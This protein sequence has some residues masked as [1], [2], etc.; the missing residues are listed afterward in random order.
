MIWIYI[1]SAIFGLVFLVPMLLGGLDSDVG[2][3]GGDAD[4]D[5]GGDADIDFDTELDSD[6]DSDS[7]SDSDSALLGPDSA[8][9]AILSSI[10]SVR[11]IV[12][13]TAFFGT[14]GV[15]FSILG[16]SSAVT[17]ATATFIGLVAAVANSV[18]FGLVKQSQSTSQISD[19][20]L[21][22][23]RAT[24]VLPLAP[25]R[26]GK[27]RIDL[28]G[29]PQ[30]MVALALESEGQLGVGDPVVV[31]KIEDGTALVA[32]LGELESGGELD[33]DN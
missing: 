6:L 14:S 4:L 28:G 8:M 30:F 2:E 5:L 10:V 26:K 27:I 25:N 7:G 12:F 33:R 21:E 29:Q 17:L 19:R 22:G 9:G 20:T 16:Y 18:L 11:T 15:V 13:F 3:L 32:S 23:R 1:A 24:V 31:V